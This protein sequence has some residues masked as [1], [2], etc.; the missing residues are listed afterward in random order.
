MKRLLL[1]IATAVLFLSGCYVTPDGHTVVW[2][3]PRSGGG[4]TAHVVHHNQYRST[5]LLISDILFEDGSTW[6]GCII[7]ELGC[8]GYPAHQ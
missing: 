6:Y 4:T 1:V 3:T 5:D 2:Q 7:P 8:T